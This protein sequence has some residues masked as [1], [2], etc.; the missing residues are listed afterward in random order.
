MLAAGRSARRGSVSSKLDQVSASGIRRFFELIDTTD[1]VISL[2]VGEP[3]FTTPNHISQAAIRSIEQGETAYT[4][5]FGLFELRELITNQ[6][7]RLYG[8][9][10]DPQT[11]VIV[12]TGVSEALNLATQAILDEGDEVI[13][14]DPSYVAYMPTV[15]FAGGKFVTVPVKAEDGFQLQP[16]A[17][18]AAI[19]PSTKAVLLGYPANPTGAVMSRESL[20]AIADVVERHDLFVISDEIYDRLVYGVEHVSFPSLPRMKERTILLGGFSKAYAMTGWRLGYVCAPPLFTDAMMR[21]HQYVMMSAPTAAQFA[22]V[23][24]LRSG[25]EDVQGMLGEYARRR[26][27]VI[28]ACR[29]MGL[30]LSEPHGAFYAFPS[31]KSTGLDDEEFAGRLLLEEKVAVVPGQAFGPGGAGHVRI[32]YAQKYELLEEALHRMA[33]FVHHY[34]T[35]AK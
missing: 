13:S 33:R 16:D 11:E 3:D 34:R 1:G 32:C 5:N 23:E 12:T 8:A 9:V 30:E 15:V 29:D 18:E 24:A 17:L 22:A 25:E 26:A 27:L 21:V 2:G 28:K 35:A 6:L 19:T 7:E 14:T 31:I 4:S 20:Q 10:Y